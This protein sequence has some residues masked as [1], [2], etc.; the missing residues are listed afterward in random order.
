MNER[1]R[2]WVFGLAILAV[3]IALFALKIRIAV[4]GFKYFLAIAV[5]LG[6]CFWLGRLG[7]K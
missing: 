1:Q 6:V 3:L 7:R 5:I 2:Q 4:A